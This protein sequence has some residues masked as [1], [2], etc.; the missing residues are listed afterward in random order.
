MNEAKGFLGESG[1]KGYIH[2]VGGPTAN[3]YGL[4]CENPNGMC[5]K[6]RCLTPH[7]CKF[8]KENHAAYLDMLRALR[9]LPGIKKV[10]IRSG[11]RFDYAL[12]QKNGEFIRE[13]AKHYVSGQL[14]LAPE[15]VQQAVL[16]VMGKPDIGV[17]ERFCQKFDAASKRA[18]KKQFVLPY[19]MSSHPGCE[20]KD[21]V[22]L[23]EYIRDSGFVPEQTQDFYPTP[24][25]LATCMYYTGMD[26]ATGKNVYVARDAREKEMQRALIHYKNPK[27]R[28]TLKQAL[29]K[30]GRED[31][32]GRGKRALIRE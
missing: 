9:E 11:I 6:R 5:E 20:L 24:G 18:G 4:R 1:F 32:I 19:F 31:L 15:H 16:T 2:D 28:A 30:A 7:P 17:Y 27:N 29:K 14:K 12:L 8:L 25:T 13:L 23:A 21:A 3:F 26:P 22:A 10:F